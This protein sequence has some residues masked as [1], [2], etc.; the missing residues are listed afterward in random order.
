M[1]RRTLPA[2][3][4]GVLLASCG[5]AQP[6]LEGDLVFQDSRPE[7][8][9]AIQLA[10]KSSY[11][12]CGV[13]LMRNGALHVLEA[14][15]RVRFTPLDGPVVAPGDLMESPLMERVAES[16]QDGAPG[17]RTRLAREELLFYRQRTVPAPQVAPEDELTVADTERG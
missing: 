14:A 13:A 9:P 5:L 15:S 3:V 7:E 16:R 8:T 12:H 1:I 11:G 10:T 4:A 2:L 6:L 17:S